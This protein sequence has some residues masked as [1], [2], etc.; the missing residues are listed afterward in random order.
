MENQAKAFV[1]LRLSPKKVG[2]AIGVEEGL[3][4]PVQTACR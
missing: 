4:R 2:R 3:G 1:L